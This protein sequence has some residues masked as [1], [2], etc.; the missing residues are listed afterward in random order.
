M[1][2]L[3]DFPSVKVRVS[4]EACEVRKAYRLATLVEKHGANFDLGLLLENLMLRGCPKWGDS[5]VGIRKL[6]C[7]LRF[8]DLSNTKPTLRVVK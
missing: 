5:D 6:R 1:R 8:T 7:R 3:S 2:T 4:C